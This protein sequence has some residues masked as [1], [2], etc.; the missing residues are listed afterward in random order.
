MAG[1]I[2]LPLKVVDYA[3]WLKGTAK[4]FARRSEALQKLDEAIWRYQRKPTAE[5]LE[6]LRKAFDGWKLSKGPEESS[7]KASGRDKNQLAS[8]LDQQLRG[9]GDGDQLGPTAEFMRP[10]LINAR[11]GVVYLFSHME[12]D[13]SIFKVVLHGAIDLTTASIDYS[14][15]QAA[16]SNTNLGTAL[17]RTSTG[18]SA[19]K[20][21]GLPGSMADKAESRLRGGDKSLEGTSIDLAPQTVTAAWMG[22]PARQP[23]DSRLLRLWQ[24]IQQW[25]W[26]MAQK[27]YAA[28]REK[29]K[30]MWDDK[31]GTAMAYIPGL[32]RKLVD[33]LV[34]KF[35]AT[36]APVIGGI[37]D[38]GGG[39]IK[40]MTAAA[41][42]YNDWLVGRNVELLGGH[43]GTIVEAIRSAMWLSVGEGLYTTLKGAGKL[44]LDIGAAGASTIASLVIA[45]AEALA[46]TIWRIV[47][48]FRI[49]SF[50]DQARDQWHAIN[51]STSLHLRPI[52]FNN[53]YKRYALTI[54]ALAVL[55]L[56]TGIC[57][58]KMR[59][60]KMF[61]DDSHVVSQ[62][63]FD[64]GS[65]YV[66][67]LK[68]WGSKYLDD[69]GF[70]FS[71]KDGL[72]SHLIEFAKQHKA[73]ETKTD[74]LLAVVS[75]FLG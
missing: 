8:L 33:F 48:I 68:V 30:A 61:K 69:A 49:R 53:W 70:S 29:V 21:T 2:Y 43:P 47:E 20:S 38:I 42:K 39:L 67:G 52:E 73:V 22:Y 31:S 72:V 58:D 37:L 19:A 62:S 7:W 65:T 12:V 40:T 63:E 17:D 32:M 71:S 18:L 41:D 56:N 75:G 66:D 25:I 54:P 46:T 28:I 16:L 27:I 5:R 13:D 35:L 50:F 60:L 15:A 57:G 14:T 24:Q 4:L 1:T 11:R 51:E 44:G 6:L 34:G 10:D 74:K 26:N 23:T 36:A 3:D 55:T 9:R 45:V 64:R 59:F